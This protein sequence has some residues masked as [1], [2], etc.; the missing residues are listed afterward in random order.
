QLC[1]QYGRNCWYGGKAKGGYCPLY[2]AAAAG[3]EAVPCTT[4]AAF[5]VCAVKL[6]KKDQ[7][8]Q[9]AREIPYV[10]QEQSLAG[11]LAQQGQQFAQLAVQ[12]GQQYAQL[13]VQQGQQWV[14]Q[15]QQFVQQIQGQL[16][17]LGG[18]LF[19]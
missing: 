8:M 16:Q 12:Q 7:A 10:A 11:Q 13:A 4:T 2:T 9:R 3:V 17:D 1:G 5:A 15:G 14:Q 6:S 19:G 18:R